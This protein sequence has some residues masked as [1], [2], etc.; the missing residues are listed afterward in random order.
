VKIIH[1][2]RTTDQT[3][4]SDASPLLQELVFGS[5]RYYFLLSPLVEQ[6]L[7]R[8]LRTRDLDLRC[9]LL[10]G[11]YQL[12]FMRVPTHAAVNETV[13]ACRQLKKPWARALVNAV[14]RRVADTPVRDPAEH[15]FGM[16]PELARRLTAAYPDNAQALLAA[17]L[18]RAP[19]SL[20]V[21]TA[22]LSPERYARVLTDAGIAAGTGWLAENL[23]LTDPRPTR[24][25]PGYAEGDVSVQD[26]GAMFAAALVQAAV[27]GV[28]RPR[29][30][31]A[32][33]APGGKLFH[34]AERL[35]RA[36]LIG[37]E[38][39]PERLAHLEREATRLSHDT[40]L[41]TLADATGRD[42]Y[43]GEPFDA[44]LL[45]APCS[46]SGTLRRHPEIK[47]H[48]QN[49]A[50]RHYVETQR[51][52]LTNLFELLRPE[53]V[54]IYCTCSLFPEE[55]DGVIEA[56][57][58]ERGD[59]RVGSLDLPVGQPTR[60]GWQLLPLPSGEAVVNRTVDGFYYAWLTR[61]RKPS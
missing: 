48:Q 51:A 35:P 8:Q 49:P 26:A 50:L 21:N 32:C 6:H 42:W 40:A 37:L 24:T 36:T 9:L 3:I 58:E 14:L 13:G 1:D 20:R 46:G 33:A 5:L 61:S 11:A 12:C 30:L 39:H 25:L 19:M 18:E 17:S 10:V 59:V 34:L 29:I 4:G 27:R 23:V 16:P 44:V 55:N 43:D 56:F 38:R 54:L 41:L 22:R 7:E 60:F 52:L 47:I 15:S 45:D 53:G 28:T 57:S 31:D 2:G